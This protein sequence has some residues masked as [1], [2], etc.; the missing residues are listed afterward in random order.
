MVMR[1]ELKNEKYKSNI[2]SFNKYFDK[3]GNNFIATSIDGKGIGLFNNKAE[4]FK[5]AKQ[6]IMKVSKNLKERK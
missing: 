1:N 3:K 6:L 5:R 4:G 2:I